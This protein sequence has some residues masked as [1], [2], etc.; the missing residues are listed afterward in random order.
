LLF[1]SMV[2]FNYNRMCKATPRLI[3]LISMESI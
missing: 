1:I 3:A 2:S